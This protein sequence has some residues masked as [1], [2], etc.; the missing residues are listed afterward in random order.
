MTTWPI[1][2]STGCF[3]RTNI[4]ECL[5]PIR[6]SGF[7]LVEICS[8][9]SHLDYHNP[10]ALRAAAARLEELGM[11]AH[12]FH[13]PFADRIDLASLD[14]DRRESSCE[15][16]I[17]AAEAAA[18]LQARYYVL[19]PGPEEAQ[20]RRDEDRLR[21]LESLVLVVNR[22]ARRCAELGLR[23]VLENK[24]PHL[25]FGNARDMLWILQALDGSDVGVC[26]DTG[27]ALLTGG[28][29]HLVE[30]LS[31][32]IRIIHAHDNRGHGD[33]HLAP[34]DGKV[35]WPWLLGALRDARFDGAF[36][37]EMAGAADPSAVLEHARRG[38]AFLEKAAGNA[39]CVS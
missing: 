39:A 10:Q 33:D 19:H 2:L 31:S 21:H 17:R 24:L 32:H 27:H 6:A 1:G 29:R 20:I 34:G 38:R 37:L 23:C 14:A 35:D 30:Q 7:S 36:M 12:S 22:V 4:L 15:E 8:S 28:F 18:A 11:E 3:H 9:P 5:E 25:L 26:L 13:A 16:I